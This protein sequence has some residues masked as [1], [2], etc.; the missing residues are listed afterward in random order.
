MNS[1]I[2]NKESIP[3]SQQFKDDLA[4]FVNLNNDI[5]KTI[6]EWVNGLDGYKS[7]S[8]EKTLIQITRKVN[9]SWDE[10]QSLLKPVLWIISKC[11]SYNEP[12]NIFVQDLVEQKILTIDNEEVISDLNMLLNKTLDL[13]KRRYEDYVP[14]LPFK[15]IRTIGSE[16]IFVSTFNKEFNVRD[17]LSESYD[18]VLET[19]SPL[20]VLDLAIKGEE[21]MNMTLVLDSEDINFLRK[22]LDLS[23]I[24]MKSAVRVIP[25]EL[26]KSYREK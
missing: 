2:L 20:L 4:Q 6:L 17:D 12:I 1:E 22:F 26:N 18:P 7:L 3:Y 14:K 25:N 23:E 5:R 16:I 8:D 11:K 21:E 24:K 10:F 15:Y 9:L 19:L 13:F